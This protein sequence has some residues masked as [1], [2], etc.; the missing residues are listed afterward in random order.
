MQLP[1][2]DSFL[3][4]TYTCGQ[5]KPQQVQKPE[6]PRAREREK[7]E[8]RGEGG[9]EERNGEREKETR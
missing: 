4:A 5:V 2:T 7:E 9:K 1:E 6:R 3:R 8:G